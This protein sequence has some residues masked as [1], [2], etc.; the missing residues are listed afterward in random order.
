MNVSSHTRGACTY[1]YQI[2]S[3]LQIHLIPFSN[4]YAR[5]VL[6]GE[7]QVVCPWLLRD[8]VRLGLWNEEMRKL[9]I[10]NN[11]SVQNI[12]CIP[13]DLKELYKTVWE[14]Q[15]KT[16][17]DMAADRG[18]FICQSQSLN[19]HLSAPSVAQLVSDNMQ[20]VEDRLTRVFALD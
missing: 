4:V 3:I 2:F 17:I 6:S 8:L 5:R 13:K 18:P 11:G 16:I 20:F 19:I 9:L 7:F 1:H 14:I 12:D 10:A 15:Q